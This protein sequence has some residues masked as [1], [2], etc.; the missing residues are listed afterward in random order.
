MTEIRPELLWRAMFRCEMCGLTDRSKIYRHKR[1]P[2]ITTHD[3]Q[4]AKVWRRNRIKIILT[5]AHLDRDITNNDPRNLR[6]L[7]QRCHNLWDA[8]HRA[9][10]R[11][12]GKGKRHG[13]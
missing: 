9:E 3:K 8:A 5:I 6:A 1:N 7:C 11:R 2:A 12:K 13:F 4:W 10:S